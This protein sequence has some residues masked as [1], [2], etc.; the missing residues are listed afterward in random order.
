MHQIEVPSDSEVEVELRVWGPL[1]KGVGPW[2][3][4]N[5]LMW[6]EGCVLRRRGSKEDC[7]DGI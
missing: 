3:E 5:L 4:K 6:D 2:A 1:L 7:Y